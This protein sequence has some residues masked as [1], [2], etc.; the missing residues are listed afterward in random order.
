MP[1]LSKHHHSGELV[2]RLRDAHE[3]TPGLMSEITDET[4]RRFPSMG[5]TGKTVRIER[6][7]GSGAWTDAAN[8][9]LR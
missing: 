3:M 2:D 8:L 5:E 9:P 1:L 4:C 7:M 6:L